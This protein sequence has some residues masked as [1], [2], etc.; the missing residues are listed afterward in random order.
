MKE[1]C[2]QHESLVGTAESSSMAITRHRKIPLTVLKEAARLA[3]RT[4]L[5]PFERIPDDV[6]LTLGTFWQGDEVVFELHIAKE[7]PRDAAVLT[8]ARVNQYDGQVRSVRVFEEAIASV[9][10]KRNA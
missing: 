2:G 8:E 10:A 5:E 9:A 7:R 1:C 6:G 4:A 3:T